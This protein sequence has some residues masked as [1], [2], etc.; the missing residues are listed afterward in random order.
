MQPAHMA[1]RRIWLTALA[2]VTSLAALPA[3]ADEVLVAVAANFAAPLQK[4]A[5]GFAAATGHVIKPSAGA[6]GKFYTQIVA[7]GAPFQ[8]LIAADDETPKKLVAE[9]HAVA[10]SNFTYA[11]GQLV[12][13]SAT[14]DLVDEQGAVL[15]AAARFSKLAIANP[16]IAPYGVAGL[17][18]V[19]ARGHT[20]A[21]TPKLVTAESISQAYQFAVTGN[22]ELAFVAL[23]QVQVPG[24]PATGSMWK[25][26]QSLYGEIRQDAVLLKPGERSAGAKA[27]LAYLKTAPAQA[28]IQAY[29][30]RH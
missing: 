14:P 1:P 29:G 10:G 30:Y 19:K 2:T 26:P 4:I 3:H 7:G 8:V 12:L 5:E 6:T 13:W 16:R 18:V 27:L 11:I 23:S 9:G 24:K 15:A 17:E 21:I 20:E 25:V 28:V 22:A